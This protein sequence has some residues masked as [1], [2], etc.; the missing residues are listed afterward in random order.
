[1]AKKWKVTWINLGAWGY[2]AEYHYTYLG[3]WINAF[4][5]RH[6]DGIENVE[7]SAADDLN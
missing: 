3:A 2:F 6:L 1:M 4:I 7:I 5:L